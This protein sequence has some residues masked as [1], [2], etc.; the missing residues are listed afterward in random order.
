MP[1]TVILEAEEVPLFRGTIGVSR[2]NAAIK[3]TERVTRSELK[4]KPTETNE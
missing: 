2:G 3:V 4:I 1:D